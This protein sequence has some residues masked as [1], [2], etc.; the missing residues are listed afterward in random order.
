VTRYLI[1]IFVDSANSVAT[2]FKK[3]ENLD[4]KYGA[5]DED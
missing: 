4:K 5:A 1:F 3:K 2:S